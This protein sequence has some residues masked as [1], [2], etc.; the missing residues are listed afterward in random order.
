MALLRFSVEDPHSPHFEGQ[1]IRLS[2][3]NAQEQLER[4]VEAIWNHTSLDEQLECYIRYVDPKIPHWRKVEYAAG[5]YF[6][7]C[8]DDTVDYIAEHPTKAALITL[9]GA[10]T[11]VTI[12]ILDT[13]EISKK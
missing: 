8:F 12:Y 2:D 11:A 3:P 9:A 6:V 4:K 1:K 13:I 7:H 5:E 10:V